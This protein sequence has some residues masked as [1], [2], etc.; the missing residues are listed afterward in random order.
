[1]NTLN[2]NR[3]HKLK[4][5]YEKFEILFA[6]YR[7]CQYDFIDALIRNSITYLSAQNNN[8]MKLVDI[9]I[10]EKQTYRSIHH[11]LLT[12]YDVFTQ[13]KEDDPK[14]FVK[15][16]F[17]TLVNDNYF[18]LND[19]YYVPSV[20]ILDKPIVIKFGSIKLSSL[21]NSITIYAKKNV[22]IFCKANIPLGYFLQL[23]VDNSVYTNIVNKFKLIHVLYSDDEIIL[24]F[25]NLFNQ[26]FKTKPD[27]ILYLEKLFFDNYTRK[28]YEHS[29]SFEENNLENIVNHSVEMLLNSTSP[30][31]IDLKN[32]RVVFIEML[33][34]P[35]F[36]KIGNAAHQASKKY[37]VDE[38]KLDPFEIVKTFKRTRDQS[39]NVDGLD[40]NYL[41]DISNLYGGTLIH[42]CSF[43]NPGSKNPPAEIANIHPTF[44]GK[45]CPIT[46]ADMTPGHT[47]S[48]VPETYLDIFGNFL[49][50]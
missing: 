42:K 41:Y 10:K 9:Q 7:K 22:C 25:N 49:N 31:F 13:S 20:Y 5:N 39:R 33:M 43:V 46:V 27:I 1:M 29:Y 47:V 15:L 4:S 6:D 48:V 17:P 32:K 14:L 26:H 16:F 3:N 24:Y 12:Q 38:L 11:N 19:N 23:F 45:I 8:Y 37:K 44:F 36:K 34:Q 28:L 18:M 35:Y 2:I 21:F 30:S 40:G 50:V